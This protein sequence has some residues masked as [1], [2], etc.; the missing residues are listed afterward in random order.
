MAR[1]ID[2]SAPA[3]THQLIINKTLKNTY[4]LLSLTLLFSAAVAGMSVAMNFPYMGFIPTLVGMYGLM[5]LTHKFANSSLGLLFVFAFTG[6]LGLTIGPTV[7]YY[8]SSATNGSEIVMTA[9]GGT[10]VIFLGLSAYVLTTRKDF[11]FMG[12]MLMTGILVAI[13]ASLANV[14]LQIPALSLAISSI[15]ILLSSGLILYQ[16]SEIIHGGET[17]YIRATVTLFVSIYNIFSSLLHI[18]GIFGGDD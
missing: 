4:M 7:N 11:S 3:S 14:F 10:G 17:N 18:L 16:T 6:F 13:V 2:A 8:M 9:M 15:F 12:G 5:F 1:I